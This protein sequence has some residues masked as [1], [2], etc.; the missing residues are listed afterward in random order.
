MKDGQHYILSYWTY[1][2]IHIWVYARTDKGGKI[3][4]KER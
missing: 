4:G 3:K 2:G 1:I